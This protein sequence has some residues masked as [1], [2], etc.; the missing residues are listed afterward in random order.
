LTA[1]NAYWLGG[2]GNQQSDTDWCGWVSCTQCT[3]KSHLVFC[4]CQLVPLS[5][6]VGVST[7]HFLPEA[8][9]QAHSLTARTGF[10]TIFCTCSGPFLYITLLPSWHWIHY[11][12]PLPIG[13]WTLSPLIL[14][15]YSHVSF[16]SAICHSLHREDGCN[17]VLH[18]IGNLP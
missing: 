17:Q 15:A 9:L 3:P 6:R 5:E 7:C 14:S 8:G 12:F 2:S 4:I 11:P 16:P 18:K 1:Q 13:C 10:L